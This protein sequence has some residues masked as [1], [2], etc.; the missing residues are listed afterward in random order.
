MDQGNPGI[1]VKNPRKPRFIRVICRHTRSNPGWQTHEF[2]NRLMIRYSGLGRRAELS[3]EHPVQPAGLRDARYAHPG[4][5]WEPE[6]YQYRCPRCRFDLQLR[7]AN[8]MRLISAL[9]SLERQRTG[10][11]A[12]RVQRLDI[13]AAELVLASFRQ[14]GEAP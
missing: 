4:R 7:A 8:M 10:N 9:D 2:P 3:A 13:S 12:A 5:L 1:P 6:T 11:Q 14:A